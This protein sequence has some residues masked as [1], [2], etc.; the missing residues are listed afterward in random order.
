VV[1]CGAYGVNRR[2]LFV[3]GAPAIVAVV[4]R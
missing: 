3:Q 2:I 4:L 1:L